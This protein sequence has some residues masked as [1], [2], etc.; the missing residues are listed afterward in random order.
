MQTLDDFLFKKLD[1]H[2][3]KPRLHETMLFH[4]LSSS[5]LDL[6]IKYAQLRSFRAG[7]HVFFEGDRGSA[8]FIILKG[9]VQ[10]VRRLKGKHAL[11]ARLSDG[12]FFGELALVYDTPRTATAVIT[13]DSL[14]VCLFKHDLDDLVKHYPSLGKKILAIVNEIMAQRISSLTK[15]KRKRT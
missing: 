2:E 1:I 5:E 12:M 10:I 6:V 4:T 9:A 7:E 13:E 11:L 15:R 3:L 8:L 14:L